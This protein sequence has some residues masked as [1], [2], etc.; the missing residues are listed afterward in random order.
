MEKNRGIGDK[1]L[2]D[3]FQMDTQTNFFTKRNIS[4]WHNLPR[5]VVDSLIFHAFK[6]QDAGPFYLDCAFAKKGWTRQFFR[7][8]PM[9]GGNS[10]EFYDYDSVIYKG[11]SFKSNA[12]CHDNALL[13]N[14]VL[15]L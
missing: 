4:H 10:M 9:E 8:L 1:L 3:R 15:I 7:I 13:H 2:L 11:G 6:I 14:V 12:S 5:E